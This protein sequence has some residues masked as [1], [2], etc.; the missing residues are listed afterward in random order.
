VYGLGGQKIG[1]SISDS[2][3]R[4]LLPLHHLSDALSFSQTIADT[5]KRQKRKLLC[6]ADCFFLGRVT[7][8]PGRAGKFLERLFLRLHSCTQKTRAVD[9]S[10]MSAVFIEY[11]LCSEYCF[12]Y[13]FIY[14]LIYFTAV[15]SSGFT[16]YQ[17]NHCTEK[18]PCCELE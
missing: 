2:N 7:V 4:D 11:T 5:C 6:T 9:L 17:N 3:K 13:L 1:S 18:C 10:E 14:L 15:T 12:V 16:R 8:K